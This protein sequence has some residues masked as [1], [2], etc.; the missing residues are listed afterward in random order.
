MNILK[1]EDQQ[2]P[3]AQSQKADNVKQPTV[4]Q[5]TGEI[6][7]LEQKNAALQ[8]RYTAL[9][10]LNQLSQDCHDLDSFYPQVHRIIASLITAE[11]FF[12]VLYEQT[13]D[14]LELF[15]IL[16]K[17]MKNLKVLLI[18]KISKDLLRT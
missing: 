7:F 2:L 10:K 8:A 16:M 5:L 4:A 9:F 6:D 14:T 15:I 12:I 11:N 3:L 18:I 17:K 1:T 13:F